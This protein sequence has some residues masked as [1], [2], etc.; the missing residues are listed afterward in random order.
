MSLFCLLI[1]PIHALY[2][3]SFCNNLFVPAPSIYTTPSFLVPLVQSLLVAFSP[4]INIFSNLDSD[5]QTHFFREN[6]ILLDICNRH[7]YF[8]LIRYLIKCCSGIQSTISIS[9]NL[10]LFNFDV[11]IWHK[12]IAIYDWRFTRIICDD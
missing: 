2:H 12:P 10:A 8:V 1:A 9:Q 7:F 6:L 3:Y 4:Y 11:Q 5:E